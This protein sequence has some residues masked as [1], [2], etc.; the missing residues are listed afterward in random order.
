MSLSVVCWKWAPPAGY[1]SSF[2]A[3]AVNVLRHMVIRRYRRPHRF[4]CVTDDATG[5]E[6][7][8]EVVPLWN[9]FGDIPSPHGV[10]KPS[11]YRR[12]KAFAPDIGSVLGERFVSLDLDVVLTE[13]VTPLWDRPEDFV[14]YEGTTDRNHYNGSMFLMTAGARPQVWTRFNPATSPQ[15]AKA[16]GCFGSDQG[17]IGFCLGAGE[18]T[19]GP[20]DGVFSYRNHL[21]HSSA[22]PGSARLVVMHGQYK[23]W[24]PQ[25][26]ARHAW[27]RQ[28]WR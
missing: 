16:A 27:L 28:H 9:D 20:R 2:S 8:V 25:M 23:P 21:Q 14:I 3:Q 26:L 6:A 17:W 19:W 12:L 10:R 15:E 5:L 7:G 1:R 11:C 13:D 22:L 18:A 4:I 24:D